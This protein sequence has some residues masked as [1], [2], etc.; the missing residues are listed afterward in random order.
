[1]DAVLFAL[2]T[3][4]RNC[5]INR[6]DLQQQVFHPLVQRCQPFVISG[7]SRFLSQIDQF[8]VRFFQARSFQPIRRLGSHFSQ[9][10]GIE[11][12]SG[13]SHW[14]RLLA[15]SSANAADAFHAFPHLYL[16]SQTFRSFLHDI[17]QGGK[18]TLDVGEG[19]VVK[20]CDKDVIEGACFGSSKINFV[21]YTT[22]VLG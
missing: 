12:R 14:L 2:L 9:T 18:H 20:C 6:L 4:K 21:Y 22:D 16:L 11:H 1:M 3:M 13:L 17:W 5:R 10:T 7:L 19:S 8:V 15:W